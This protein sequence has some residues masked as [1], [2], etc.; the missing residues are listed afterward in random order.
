MVTDFSGGRWMAGNEPVAGSR[1]PLTLRLPLPPWLCA[2]LDEWPAP[3]DDDRAGMA[4][5][6]ALARENVRQKTGGP[7][8]AVVMDCFGAVVAPGVNCVEPTGQSWAHAEML[9]LSLAQQGLGSHDL[10]TRVGAPMTLYST[11]EPC[12][13]CLGAIPWSGIARVVVAAREADIAAI[14]FD[15]GDKPAAG[16]ASLEGRGIEVVRDV[17]RD[18]ACAILADYAAA[19]GMLYHP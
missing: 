17:Q 2:F 8:A 1:A 12:A 7:F 9:A 13:M 18:E 11:G 5:A 15:E 14:G 3:L 19:G 16:L 6:I 4:L 10:S